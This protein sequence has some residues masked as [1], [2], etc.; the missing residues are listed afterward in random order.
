VYGLTTID[1]LPEVAKIAYI[2]VFSNVQVSAV[3]DQIFG[4]SLN[5][6]IVILFVDMLLSTERGVK[7]ALLYFFCVHSGV[8][9]LDE[10]R[11]CLIT[12]RWMNGELV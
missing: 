12:T 4:V 8:K 3:I 1:R 2:N 7:R 6:I 11:A 9:A 5:G 10:R